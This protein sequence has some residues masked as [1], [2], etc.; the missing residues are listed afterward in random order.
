M[1][2]V[3]IVMAGSGSRAKLSMNKALAIIEG[4]PLFMYSYLLFKRLNAEIVL[5]AKEDEIEEI[6]KYVDKD[7]IITVG[8]ATR[9]KSVYNGLLQCTNQKVLVHDAARP[10]IEDNMVNQVV[11]ALDKNKAAYV[12]IKVKDTIRDITINEVIKRDNLIA[13][14][15]PQAAYLDD[16]KGAYEVAF[17]MG[18]EATDD[19]SVLEKFTNIKAK[20]IEGNDINFKITTPYDVELAK[21]IIK[22]AIESV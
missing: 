7:T 1:F 13:A 11:S 12:G 2:S 17:K 10:F 22:G 15:T 19:I 4:R 18:Y 8:G 20:L 16:L 3:V 5:V 14:Q 21:V 6:K 9:A